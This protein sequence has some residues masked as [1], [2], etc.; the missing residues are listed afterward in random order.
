VLTVPYNVSVTALAA[1]LTAL[2]GALIATDL[3]ATLDTASD[4]TVFAPSNDAFAAI[5]SAAGTLST[6]QLAS[7]LEYHVISGTVAY[8]SSLGNG[9]VASLAGGDLNITVADG[10]MYV[11]R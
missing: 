5:G 3:L 11:Y 7:I 10:A 4:I 1:D 6:S 2:A 9:S 8:S